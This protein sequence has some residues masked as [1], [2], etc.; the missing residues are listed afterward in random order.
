M[1]Y[2]QILSI[3]VSK[4]QI[5][6]DF[7]VPHTNVSDDKAVAEFSGGTGVGLMDVW[8]FFFTSDEFI[9]CLLSTGNNLGTTLEEVW[10]LLMEGGIMF[11][12][13]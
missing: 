9:L 11:W 5:L 4:K 7:S 12:S 3:V 10:V 1:F 2:M 13:L 8:V 6:T